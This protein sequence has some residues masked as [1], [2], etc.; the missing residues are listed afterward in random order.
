[1]S[2]FIDAKK[3][4]R[5]FAKKDR[6]TALC[7]KGVAPFPVNDKKKPCFQGLSLLAR[8]LRR[9]FVL[10]FEDRPVNGVCPAKLIGFLKPGNFQCYQFLALQFIGQFLKLVNSDGDPGDFEVWLG[11]VTFSYINFLK[12]FHSCKC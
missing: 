4:S 3:S 6:K 9:R 8:F 12:F 2:V 1:M 11:V 7:F 5:F 10:F